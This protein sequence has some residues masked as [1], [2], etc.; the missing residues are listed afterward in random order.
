MPVECSAKLHL[1]NFYISCAELYTILIL[2]IVNQSYQKKIRF[3][4]TH[5]ELSIIYIYLYTCF[6]QLSLSLHCLLVVHPPMDRH[7]SSSLESGSW[8]ASFMESSTVVCSMHI[9]S[10]PANSLPLFRAGTSKVPFLT[11]S[12]TYHL[13]L[14]TWPHWAQSAVLLL[15]TV[16]LNLGYR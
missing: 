10:W 3:C 9:H 6:C 4:W 14:L 16:G 5:I 13:M 15:F 2:R 11:T 8:S 7:T 12:V 1:V